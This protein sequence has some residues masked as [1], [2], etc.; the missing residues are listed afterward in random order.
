VGG[1]D[2]T[3]QIEVISEHCDSLDFLS[4]QLTTERDEFEQDQE[5]RKA[6]LMN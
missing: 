6:E 2:A 5:L 4:E 3:S 1:S